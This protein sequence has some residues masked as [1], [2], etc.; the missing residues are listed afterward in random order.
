M[1][2]SLPRISAAA[3]GATSPGSPARASRHRLRRLGSDAPG[4]AGVL[5]GAGVLLRPPAGTADRP[6]PGVR[7]QG[8][9][10]ECPYGAGVLMHLR[11]A[12]LAPAVLTLARILKPG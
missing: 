7:N 3:A 1:A 2:L 6:G 12:H 11:R 5:P 9:H 8:T 10:E 4:G